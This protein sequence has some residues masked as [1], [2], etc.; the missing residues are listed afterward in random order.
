MK[1]KEEALERIHDYISF[2]HWDKALQE[3]EAYRLQAI[4]EELIELLKDEQIE[5]TYGVEEIED[6][7]DNYLSR[8]KQ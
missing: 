2:G 3:L 6:I 5:L 7:V 4:R 1:T 8:R